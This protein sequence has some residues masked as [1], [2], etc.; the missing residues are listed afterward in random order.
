MSSRLLVARSPG[1]TQVALLENDVLTDF[2]VDMD[3]AP[4]LVGGVYTAIVTKV[5]AFGQRATVNTGLTGRAAE[6]YV[7]RQKTGY[8]PSEGRKVLVQIVRDELP[9][10]RPLGSFDP[11]LAGRYLV[12]RISVH[13]APAKERQSGKFSPP[14]ASVLAGLP[15]L[16]D[17]RS[18]ASQG[19]RCRMAAEA[20]HL[21]AVA[22]YAENLALDTAPDGAEVAPPLSALDW[23]QQAAVDDDPDLVV[24]GNVDIQKMMSSRQ[25]PERSADIVRMYGSGGLPQEAD[26][27]EAIEEALRRRSSLA[28]AAVTIDPTEA[29]IAVDIDVAPSLLRVP[30]RQQLLVEKVMGRI[31]LLNLG[32]LIAVDL[33]SPVQRKFAAAG[34]RIAARLDPLPLRFE[35]P[36]T[37]NVLLVSR[38][39]AR[40]SLLEQVFDTSDL[41]GRVPKPEWTALSALAAVSRHS[42]TNPSDHIR[43][44]ANPEAVNALNSILK[45]AVIEAETALGHSIQFV[46]D[47][48]DPTCDRAFSIDSI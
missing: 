39:R 28:G 26:I 17:E 41:A 35:P 6:I 31:R 8:W 20:R 21:A 2:L 42:A 33:P 19:C 29:L 16:W 14:V 45:E 38:R 18:R 10:K 43:I 40:A 37:F 23:L 4:S 44:R 9:G 1:R 32:G 25:L 47:R 34:A 12:R 27:G 11:V 46:M 7:N 22:R 30:A 48:I 5:D 3:H 13:G 24:T 15:G 36:G